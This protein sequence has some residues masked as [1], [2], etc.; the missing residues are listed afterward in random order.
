MLVEGAPGDR[1]V[2]GDVGDGCPCVAVF[3]DRLGEA[4]D[5]PLALVVGD[6]L[7]WQPV[8]SGR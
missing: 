6:E 3:S 5:Q 4:G 8:P 7:A 1:R 2:A